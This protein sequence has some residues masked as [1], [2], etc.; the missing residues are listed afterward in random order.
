LW[1]V[2]RGWAGAVP[3]ARQR[4]AAGVPHRADDLDPEVASADDRREVA[5]TEDLEILPDQ[6]TDDTDAG[7]GERRGSNDDYLLAERP[8]HWD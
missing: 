4:Y 7:W 6:T 8:P 5:L 1:R 2:F 3:L